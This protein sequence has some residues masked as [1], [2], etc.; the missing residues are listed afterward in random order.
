MAGAQVTLTHAALIGNRG[1][2][3]AIY[4]DGGTLNVTDTRIDDNRGTE[5]PAEVR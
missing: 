2:A 3:G 5:A 1:E 4:S